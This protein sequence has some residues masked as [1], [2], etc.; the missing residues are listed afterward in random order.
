MVAGGQLHLHVVTGVMQGTV[1]EFPVKKKV[2]IGRT[3][4]NAFPI[5]H[6]T[7]SQRHAVI[8]HK[9]GQW[10][11]TDSN[12]SNGT[13]VNGVPVAPGIPTG[14][15]DGDCISIGPENQVSVRI[16]NIEKDD[17]QEVELDDGRRQP[18]LSSPQRLTLKEWFEHEKER[19]AEENESLAETS[20]REMVEYAEA[21]KREICEVA[22]V[23]YTSIS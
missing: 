2:T 13:L 3:R 23:E 9:N 7:V 17:D 11:V 12:S 20:V 22:G 1:T 18:E 16:S 21:L 15:R 5:K 4:V 8:V 10:F 19:L 14:L 6:D